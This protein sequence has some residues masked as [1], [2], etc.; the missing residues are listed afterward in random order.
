VTRRDRYSLAI[1]TGIGQ[2]LTEMGEHMMHVGHGHHSGGSHLFALFL[3]GL[4]WFAK[5]KEKDK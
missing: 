1:A 5:V 4:V 2:G 3:F